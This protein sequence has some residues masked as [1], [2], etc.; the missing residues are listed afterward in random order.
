MLDASKLKGL[1]WQAKTA[2]EEG[3]KKTYGT[4][5]YKRFDLHYSPD[6]KKKLLSTL[7]KKP[8][9]KVLGKDVVSV[10]S[11]DGFKF[12]RS[13]GSWFMLRPSGTEPKLRIYSEAHS[14]KEAIRLIEFG[15]RFALSI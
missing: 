8:F 12:I 14:E 6:K 5:V 3:I 2:L 13:D 15:K 10:K 11:F 4:Y 7:K 1:G 9:K